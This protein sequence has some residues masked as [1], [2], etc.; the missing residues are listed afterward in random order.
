M[1]GRHDRNRIFDRIDAA[2][3]DGDL[4]DARQAVVDHFRAKVVELEQHVV[5]VRTAAA[6]FVDLDRHG[7][8]HHVARGEVLHGRRVALHE[9]L[10]IGVEQIAALA[11]NPLGDQHPGTRHAGGVELPELHVLERNAGAGTHAQ[12]VAGV[13]K[14]VGARGEDATSAA[15]GQQRGSRLQDHAFAGLHLER[16]HANHIAVSIADQIKR[17]PFDEELGAGADVALIERVQHGVAG[18]IGRSAGALH[19]AGAE[20]LSVAAER[21]LVDLAV[22][23]TVERHTEMLELDD[24]ARRHATHVFDRVL[25][26]EPIGALDRVVH[27]P[28]PVVFLRIAK[29][30]RNAALRCHGVAAGRKHL[31]QHGHLESGFRELQG[32]AQASAAGADNH[33]IKGTYGQSHQWLQTSSMT[34]PA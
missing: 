11:A 13:D 29:A 5:F 34:Q 16:D 9:A 3:A 30:R 2:E 12:A 21:T 14:G 28:E 23:Q 17:H 20:L 1:A 10:T 18:A 27:V 32:G 24:H 33:R 25:V 15:G 19:R 4:A 8:R 31:G 26:A 7:A 22:V 6:A